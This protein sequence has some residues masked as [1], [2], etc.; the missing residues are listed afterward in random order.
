MPANDC[1]HFFGELLYLAHDEIRFF[2]TESKDT[3]PRL[4][5][6]EKL[7]TLLAALAGLTGGPAGT[8]RAF[9][10]ALHNI[11]KG[12]MD[13]ESCFVALCDRR[14]ES[15]IFP[16]LVEGDGESES[17]P[18][19][20]T[21]WHRKLVGY[22]LHTGRPLSSP[23]AV[24]A[25]MGDQDLSEKAPPAACLGV[26]LIVGQQSIGA[27]VVQNYSRAECYGQREKWL[28]GVLAQ[29]L[30]G[31][32]EENHS[33][34]TL[35]KRLAERT[36]QHAEAN[37]ALKQQDEALERT[38]KA[39]AKQV[40]ER[41]GQLSRANRLLAN[42]ITTRKVVERQL[43]HDALH[44]AMTGLPNRILLMDR[45]VQAFRRKRRSKSFQFAVLFLDLD[46]FKVINDSLGH[47][48]GD[49]LLKE[50]S[51]RSHTCM[52]D[53]DTVARF[54]GDEFVILLESFNGAE[55]VDL[56]ARRITERLAEA[57]QLEGRQVHATTSIGI[58]IADP[59]SRS[60]EDLLRDADAAMY[61]AKETGRNRHV[62][63]DDSMDR[64]VSLTFDTDLKQVM[65]K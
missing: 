51:Q 3:A 33:R 25:A 14:R 56:I 53:S 7:R 27:L 55:E 41:T 17:R 19:S 12:T 2:L 22:L 23:E 28:L 62:F 38:E 43:L 36:Q 39:L 24:I 30:A 49:A 20:P 4:G 40:E 63:F 65:S 10:T 21:P 11:L 64:S 58:A 8:M 48:A 15:I 16:Y 52:R 54:G 5:N 26:P 46:C 13:A 59:R 61:H 32:L 45:L 60:P 37:G 35:E 47:L 1:E 29:A 42:Q 34:D 57:Y 18:V 44:D 50:V 9:Y 31:I 6:S